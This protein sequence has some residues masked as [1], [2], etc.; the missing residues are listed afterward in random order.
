MNCGKE[1]MGDCCGKCGVKKIIAVIPV[2][3]R[4]PLIKHTIE[5]LYKRNGIYKV[6]CVGDSVIDKKVCLQSGADWV[7]FKNKPLGAK[8][9]E[10]FKAAEK[11][12]PDGCLFVGSSDWISDNWMTVLSQYLCNYDLIGL[13]GCYLLDINRTKDTHRALHW[14]GYIGTREGES[15]GIGRLISAKVLDK[16]NWQ[17]FG[18]G[19]DHSLDY[20]MKERVMKAGGKVKLVVTDQVKSMAISCSEWPN[21]HNFESHWSN[22]L[23]SEKID[24]QEL[25]KMF[26]ESLEIFK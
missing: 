3:G 22:R 23:P 11:Y 10:G 18:A 6:I 1:D 15:I 20:S 14:P 21:K 26:P 25:F 16:M 24:P 2:H 5:R 4:R 9:N 19:L 13:P 12:Q 8:W 17:P 7:Q